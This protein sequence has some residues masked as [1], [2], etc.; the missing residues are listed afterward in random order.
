[1]RKAQGEL[2]KL[3]AKKEGEV[4]A[5]AGATPAPAAGSPANPAAVKKGVLH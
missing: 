5:A 3:L 1:V 4:R 2:S